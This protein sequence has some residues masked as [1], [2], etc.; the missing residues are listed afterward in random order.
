MEERSSQNEFRR[1]VL[2]TVELSGRRNNRGWDTFACS[3]HPQRTRAATYTKGTQ[4]ATRLLVLSRRYQVAG[5]IY[6]WTLS[7]GHPVTTILS[8]PPPIQAGLLIDPSYVLL[9]WGARE[10]TCC[11]SQVLAW[12][13]AHITL[14]ASQVQLVIFAVM[15]RCPSLLKR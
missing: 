2:H 3:Q 1:S 5:S 11:W 7:T 10:H 12:V 9:A 4:G 8:S 13:G 15:G 14:E 6:S